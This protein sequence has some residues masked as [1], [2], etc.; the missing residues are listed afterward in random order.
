MKIRILFDQ[1]EKVYSYF[2]HSLW[3][4]DSHLWPEVLLLGEGA[5]KIK[6]LY[7]TYVNIVKSFVLSK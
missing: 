5:Y 7:I 2:D 4:S 3:V 6:I 1:P